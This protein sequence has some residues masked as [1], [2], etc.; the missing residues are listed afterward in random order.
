MEIRVN[1]PILVTATL[2]LLTRVETRYTA[3]VL[4]INYHR[5]R[6]LYGEGRQRSNF[7]CLVYKKNRFNY[8]QKRT[9][10]TPSIVQDVIP[11]LT[12]RPTSINYG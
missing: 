8:R 5:R 1:L 11:Q 9:H 6:L 12:F 10:G 7:W 4:S 2:V 3:T